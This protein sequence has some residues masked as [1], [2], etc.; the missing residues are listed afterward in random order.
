[1]PRKARVKSPECIYHVMVRSVGGSPLFKCDGDKNKFLSLVKKYQE[2][3][4]F[5]VYAYCLMDNHAHLLIDAAGADIS[6]FM[7]VINQCYTQHYYNIK[8]ERV[9]HLFADRFKSKII[10]DDAYLLTASGYIHNNPSDINGFEDKVY[11]YPYSSLGIY[12]GL[13]EDTNNIIDTSFVMSQFSNDQTKARMLYLKFVTKCTDI[14]VKVEIEFNDE[15]SEYRSERVIIARN[16]TPSQI[17]EYV[18]RYTGETIDNTHVKG[19][20]RSREF[21]SLVVVMMRCMCNYTHKQICEAMNNI[22]ISQ[23][24]KLLYQGIDLVRDNTKYPNIMCAFIKE[25]KCSNG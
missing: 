12:L 5:K 4:L 24:S 21:R 23:V 20:K 17:I 25:C 9:G 18:S 1:M 14:N 11:E 22:T 13:R 16:Y 15:K 10:D 2:I 19:S 6:K 8:Y 3:F 7:H